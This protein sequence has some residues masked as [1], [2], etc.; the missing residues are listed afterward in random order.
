MKST[1][2]WVWLS[3]KCGAGNSEFITLIERLGS[4]E[5]IYDASPEQLLDTGISE[6]LADALSDKNMDDASGVMYYCTRAGVGIVCYDDP[7]YPKSLKALK[8]PPIVLYFVGTLPDMN[9]RLCISVVGT[10]KMSEYGK[11]IA[12]KI[13][14]E[15]ASTG[16]VVVSGMAL[17]IDGIA[18][19]AAIAAQGKTVA[20]LGCGI[21][22]VYPKC[23]EK[24][25]EIIKHNGA[26]IT[27]FPPSTEP[28][29][30]N[31]PI[32]NR[33]IS[34]LGQGTLVVDADKNSGAMITAQNAILQGKDI[35][36][37]PANVGAENT[38]GTNALIRDGAMA[39][40]CGRDI[41]KNYAYLYHDTIDISKLGHAEK[42]SDFDPAVVE[43]MGIGMRSY[44]PSRK[45][46]FADHVT[47]PQSDKMESE[48]NDGL[49]TDRKRDLNDTGRQSGKKG[50]S[51]GVRKEK[52]RSE[53]EERADSPVEKREENASDV[54]N[55]L[56]DK[57]KRIF[58]EIPMDR[59]VTVDV[60]TRLG[61]SMGEVMS[62]LTVLE[63]KGLISSL[64]GALYI[65]K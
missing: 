61:F 59:P 63:I 41:I 57:Q 54:L 5:K 64:P 8:A 32:R 34:G 47:E 40:L 36:A 29:G 26:V 22:I 16:A 25:E 46:T 58:E 53:G 15:I 21:D 60:L 20:V 2:K 23:H 11:R 55:S 45:P 49:R 24:L 13:S 19:C 31:F 28:K 9:R 48:V 42:N 65:R 62:A 4:A 52:N 18:S 37:V 51:I 50:M 14:Y 30:Y 6:R 17:G 33:I 43:R 10:R 27:E 7:A 35:Y 39:V 56:N 38:S 12:Y 44:A 3:L 1:Q